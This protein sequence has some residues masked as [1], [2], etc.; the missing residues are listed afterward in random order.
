[1]IYR[2]CVS[3]SGSSIT[4]I[5]I[6]STW[7]IVSD[8]HFGQNRGKFF[9]IVSLRILTLVLLEHMGH[10][11]HSTTYLVI[12]PSFVQEY[13]TQWTCFHSNHGLTCNKADTILFLALIQKKTRRPIPAP[14]RSLLFLSC[15]PCLWEFCFSG[16]TAFLSAALCSCL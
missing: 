10:G 14:R 3:V 6:F 4:D 9:R 8:L 2:F 13:N 12:V 15:Y 11:T 5:F 1:M 16:T 7:T